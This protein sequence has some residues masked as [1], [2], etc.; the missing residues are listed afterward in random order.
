MQQDMFNPSRQLDL[1]DAPQRPAPIR[2]PEAET[3]DQYNARRRRE[4]DQWKAQWE[5]FKAKVERGTD[6]ETL[7]TGDRTRR[8]EH[9]QVDLIRLD[10]GWHYRQDYSYSTGGGGGPYGREAYAT[11]DDALTQCLRLLLEAM[12]RDAATDTK[13]F[14]PAWRTWALEV[15]PTPLFG[16]ADLAAEYA[17]MLETFT[18]RNQLRVAAI[19]AGAREY[20][21][22][23]GELR[24]IYSL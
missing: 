9:F 13:G 15:A 23:K 22:E 24:S 6:H 7:I 1:F 16:G 4:A 19:R 10:D 8:R 20:R 3:V 14:P 18:A 17:A 21:D 12:A 11:R 2:P 5:A